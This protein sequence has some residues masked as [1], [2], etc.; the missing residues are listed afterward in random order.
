MDQQ[1]HINLIVI[2][3][4]VHTVA[5]Y[6]PLDLGVTSDGGE[7]EKAMSLHPRTVSLHFF[8]TCHPVFYDTIGRAFNIDASSFIPDGNMVLV[9]WGQEMS[10]MI[11]FEILIK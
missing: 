6:K 3:R 7:G 4:V 9:V 8:D 5:V 10:S 2:R 11:H 1:E